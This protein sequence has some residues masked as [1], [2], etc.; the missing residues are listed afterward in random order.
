MAIWFVC[1]LWWH[2]VIVFDN[3]TSWAGAPQRVDD[4]LGTV[5]PDWNLNPDFSVSMAS[6]RRR[7]AVVIASSSTRTI[8][9]WFEG[10]TWIVE[11]LN[12]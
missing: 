7:V 10:Q 2:D 1:L 8:S 9:I 3:V 6:R 5:D 11:L 12:C 4:D